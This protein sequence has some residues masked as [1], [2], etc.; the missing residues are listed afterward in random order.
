MGEVKCSLKNLSKCEFFKEISH[1]TWPEIEAD[2]QRGG[3]GDRLP[4]KGPRKIVVNTNIYKQLMSSHFTFRS[5]S[6]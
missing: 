3:A 6:M 1:T 2:T 4:K 5:E